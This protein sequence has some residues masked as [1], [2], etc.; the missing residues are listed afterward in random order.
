MQAPL[1]SDRF[2]IVEQI[3]SYEQGEL[4]QDET[5][6]LFQHLIDTGLAWTLQGHYGGMATALVHAGYCTIQRRES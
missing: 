1:H 4:D 2:N 5:I 3:M 6:E